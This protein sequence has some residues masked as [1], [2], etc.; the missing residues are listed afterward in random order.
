MT[1]ETHVEQAIDRVRNEQVAIDDKKTAYTQFIR[2][3]EKTPVDTPADPKGMFQTT[4]GPVA[5]THSAGSRGVGYCKQVSECFNDTVRAHNTADVEN[6]D[7]LLEA[8]GVELSEQ[9]AMALS[10]R[11][12]AAGFTNEVKQGVLSE[13]TERQSELSAMER[14]LKRERASLVE[15]KVQLD[16]PIQ[17]I[18]DENETPLTELDFTALQAYHDRLDGFQAKC[19]TIAS[20]RQALLQATTS[21]NGRVGIAHQ[22]L[23]SCL[24]PT[25]PVAYPVLSTSVRV[26]QV[27]EH[28]QQVIRDHLIRR[29]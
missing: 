9:I 24:Y 14:A 25:F 23:V 22:E 3:V 27:C 8:I 26:K 29:V 16:E 15:A 28:C 19:E 18:V 21:A 10:P 7:N 11:N 13:A 4:I 1:V 6:P 20:E 2:E 5:T 17:W 12:A